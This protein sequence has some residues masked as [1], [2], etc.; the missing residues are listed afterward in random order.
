MAPFPHILLF[1]FFLR[2][3]AL[4]QARDAHAAG[5]L[6]DAA[7]R[8]A[9]DAAILDFIALQEGVN[10]ITLTA[11]DANGR[12]DRQVLRITYRPRDLNAGSAQQASQR[13]AGL[14]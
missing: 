8:A 5:N 3:P 10:R 14:E 6:S 2:P 4:L 13:L 9:E 12:T 7:L 1:A 11:Q